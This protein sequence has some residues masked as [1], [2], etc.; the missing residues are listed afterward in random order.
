M[1][2][3][4]N[5]KDKNTGKE[6]SREINPLTEQFRRKPI[7]TIEEWIEL[8]GNPQHSSPTHTADLVLDSYSVIRNH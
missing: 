8:R 4:I 5:L 7:E 6:F 3:I 1:L 2:V